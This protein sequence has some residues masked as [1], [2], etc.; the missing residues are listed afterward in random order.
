MSAFSS[1][2]KNIF[3][4]PLLVIIAFMGFQNIAYAQLTDS[5]E[6]LKAVSDRDGDEATKYIDQGLINTK[7]RVSGVTAL[8]IVVDR[9]DALWLR[10]LL[11]KN[12]RPDVKDRDGISPLIRAVELNFIEGVEHLI[13]YKADVDYPN[14]SGETPLIKAVHL[15]RVELIPILLE[16]GADPDRRDIIQGLSAREYATRDPRAGRILAMIENFEEEKKAKAAKDST[17]TLD[18][19]GISGPSLD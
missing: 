6:F 3:V 15:D 12:A 13:K 11:Q 7:K 16:A 1:F 10:F 14:R 2:A 17:N 8:H 4:K 19:S 9:R 18:F 5:D